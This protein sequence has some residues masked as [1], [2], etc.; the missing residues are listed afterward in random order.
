[1]ALDPTAATA[2]W[3]ANLSAAGPSI[4]AGVNA[5]TVAP[6][7]SAAKAVTTWLARVQAS[8]PKWQK[9][10]GAVTLQEWQ[11]AMLDK[12]V[13]RI[14]SGA[15]AA[16]GKYAAFATSFF[17]YLAQGVAKVKAMPKTDLSSSIARAVAMIQHN[18]A[19]Q[20]PA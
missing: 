18:A 9:N 7:A 15:Q 13:P 16:Q 6:G 14:A 20:K 19:Y 5:V 12:G 11:T 3:V 8:A 10:V 1:M 2:K 17:P 4:T